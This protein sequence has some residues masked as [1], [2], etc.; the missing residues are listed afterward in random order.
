LRLKEKDDRHGGR[1][2][3][4]QPKLD[5]TLP[6]MELSKRKCRV[7]SVAVS[8]FGIRSTSTEAK[9]AVCLVSRT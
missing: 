8:T 3:S 2:A 1:P 5:S 9:K 4:K 7:P 6:A